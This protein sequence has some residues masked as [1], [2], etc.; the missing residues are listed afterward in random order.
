MTSVFGVGFFVTVI[1]VDQTLGRE[2][3]NSPYTLQSI[4]KGKSGEE[5][6]A[7]PEAES[8]G[9][10]LLLLDLLCSITQDHVPGGALP[11]QQ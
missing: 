2:G 10:G 4:M 3:S 9:R 1:E 6:K 8:V 7:G 5:L 11:N